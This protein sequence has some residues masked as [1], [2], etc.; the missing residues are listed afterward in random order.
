VDVNNT[1]QF[2]HLCPAACHLHWHPWEMCNTAQRNF[3][4]IGIHELFTRSA[5]PYRYRRRQI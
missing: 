2:V 1:P 5:D 3:V 4:N